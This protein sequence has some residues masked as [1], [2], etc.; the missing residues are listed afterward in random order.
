MKRKLQPFERQLMKKQIKRQIQPAV[1]SPSGS[2][3]EQ[4]EGRAVESQSRDRALAAEQ[5]QQPDFYNQGMVSMVSESRSLPP[6]RQKE[7]KQ[8][9]LLQQSLIAGIKKRNRHLALRKSKDKLHK[10]SSK[11]S[12]FS[13]Q[14]RSNTIDVNRWSKMNQASPSPQTFE[15]PDV[16]SSIDPS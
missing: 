3:M 8:E 11:E 14:N 16:N 6:L 10:N 9:E 5:T 15:H 4:V 1:K 12:A 13:Y 7:V 2:K